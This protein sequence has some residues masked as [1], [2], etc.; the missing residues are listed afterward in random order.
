MLGRLDPSNYAW[1]TP[2]LYV[3]LDFSVVRVLLVGS[4]VNMNATS[5]AFSPQLSGLHFQRRQ[6]ERGHGNNLM[7]LFN[8]II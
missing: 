6:N 8:V 2:M 1:S 5:N 3:G 7:N 4:L